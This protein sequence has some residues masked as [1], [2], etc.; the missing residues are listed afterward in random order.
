VKSD[1]WPGP[2][3]LAVALLLIALLAWGVRVAAAT[4]HRL[5]PDEALYG[6]WGLLIVSGRDPWLASVPVYKPPFLPYVLAAS[7]ALLGRSELAVRLPGLVAGTATVALTARLA[8]R[9]YRDRLAVMAAGAVVALSPFSVL[10]FTTGF[11]DPSMVVLGL[12]GCVAAAE[13]RPV[14]AGVLAGLSFSAKQTGLVWLPLVVVFTVGLGPSGEDPAAAS[15]ARLGRLFR[16]VSCF[17]FVAALTLVWDGVR[18]AQGAESFWRAGAVAYGG[19]RVI[20][21]TEWGP[22]LQAWLGWLRLLAGSPLLG[23][24]LAGGALVLVVQGLRRRIWAALFDFSLSGF[25]LLYL[26]LHWLWAFPVWDRYLL[27]LVP[28][29]G[30]LLGRVVSV[31]AQRVAD[32]GAG[33]RVCRDGRR[34]MRVAVMALLVLSLA[35]PAARALAGRYPMGA[36]QAAYDGIEQVVG[37]LRTRSEGSVLYHHWLGWEYAFHLFDG[38]LYLAYWPT[39]AWLAQDVQVFG[40]AEP[41]YVVFP[42]W[43]SPARVEAALAT[44][45]YR[46]EPVLEVRGKGGEVRFTVYRVRRSQAER[47]VLRRAVLSL[48]SAC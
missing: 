25:C 12:A 43:E 19:L 20:W 48:R 17:A 2:S 32:A 39:P 4:A 18:V 42:A 3:V 10:L 15:R 40:E 22:R 45:G 24:L 46:L 29:A 5:H 33:L 13:G 30:V 8:W 9:L 6:F 34:C 47:P 38:P 11:T 35:I 1:R 23:A 28:L 27:P 41:R 31:L 16:V 36:G 44:V 7:L 14:W 26:L 21:P 37:Y